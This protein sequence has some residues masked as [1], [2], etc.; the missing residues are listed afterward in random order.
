MPPKQNE[1]VIWDQVNSHAVEESG[2]GLSRGSVPS[3]TRHTGR[4]MPRCASA[5][6]AKSFL[7]VFM[8]HSGSTAIMTELDQHSQIYMSGYEPVDHGQYAKNSSMSLMYADDFFTEAARLNKTGGFK[9]RPRNL[10]ANPEA[11]S[12]LIA[13]HSTRIL[14]NYRQNTFKMSVS[15]YPIVHLGDRSGY[16]GLRVN[17][18]AMQRRIRRFRIHDMEALHKILT[19]RIAGEQ[20]VSLALRRLSIQQCV[21]PL[22]YESYL[23]QHET[24]MQDVQRFLGVDETERHPAQRAKAMNVNLCELVENWIDVCNP[25]FGCA[26]WR[27]LMDDYENGCSC[28]SHKDA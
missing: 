20:S 16:E 23:R 18:S 6:Q 2:A 8:G 21:L 14:W 4:E 11:W 22:S 12:A 10:L 17:D 1:F 28:N 27:A 3:G 7:L 19:K 25:F 24:T 5:G 26:E 13:K 9:I 15:H